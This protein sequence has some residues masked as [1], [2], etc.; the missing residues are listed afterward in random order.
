MVSLV[1]RATSILVLRFNH[2]LLGAEMT[3]SEQYGRDPRKGKKEFSAAKGFT[4]IELMVVIG[5]I[6]IIASLALPSYRTLIEKRQVTSGAEQISAFL[7]SAQLEAVKRNE[8]VGVHYEFNEAGNW[9]LG[10]VLGE[11]DCTCS[12]DPDTNTCL[13]D[14]TARIMIPENLNYEEALV[15]MDGDGAFVIDPVRGMMADFTDSPV[16]QFLSQP[17]ETYALNAVMNPTGRVIIC[18]DGERSSHQ[19]PGFDEC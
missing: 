14:G 5:V 10:A 9:C 17:E 16:F 3:T 15:G 1:P 18:S 11:E 12:S 2:M 6:A 4:V 8:I 19:V 13:I 7:S